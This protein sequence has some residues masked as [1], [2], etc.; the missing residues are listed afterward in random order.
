MQCLLA[1]PN[2]LLACPCAASIADY[3]EAQE[4]GGLSGPPLFELSTQVLAEMYKLTGKG[5]PC[6]TRGVCAAA[7]NG[8]VGWGR[9]WAECHRQ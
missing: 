2:R 3:P 4:T 7:D 1:A 6:T 5:E 9:D 8:A